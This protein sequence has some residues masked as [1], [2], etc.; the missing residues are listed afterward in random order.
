M[1]EM[2]ELGRQAVALLPEHAQQARIRRLIRAQDMCSKH[3]E[4]P[5]EQQKLQQTTKQELM[6]IIKHLQARE[7]ERM[8][9]K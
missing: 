1:E 7:L 5:L 2:D 6:P 8:T 3:I 9:Y 4:L